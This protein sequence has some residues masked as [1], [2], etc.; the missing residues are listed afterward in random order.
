MIS[1]EALK[2]GPFN[3]QFEAWDSASKTDKGNPCLGTMVWPT[4]IEE[5]VAPAGKEVE[6]SFPYEIPRS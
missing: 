6:Y 2:K 1:P 3:S 5:V 4:E